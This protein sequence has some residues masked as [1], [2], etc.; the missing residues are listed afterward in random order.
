MS[1]KLTALFTMQ[2]V[3]NWATLFTDRAEE[4]L[5]K[6]LLR[7]GEYFVK[8]ARSNGVYLNHTGNLRS[9]IGY[10]IAENGKIQEENFKLQ[11]VGSEGADGLAKAKKLAI[12]LANTYS[13]GFVLIGVAGEDY[14]AYVER[15]DSKDVIYSSS[16][17]LEKFLRDSIKAVM[18]KAKEN[19]RI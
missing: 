1:G 2:D 10:V 12:E 19:G 7:A 3:N 6:L 8:E 9:S 13:E 14:A 15:I 16:R 17:K 5:L 4:K 11:N 18:K